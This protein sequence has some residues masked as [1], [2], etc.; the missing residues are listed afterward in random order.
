MDPSHKTVDELI[1]HSPDL[2]AV[3]ASL[4]QEEEGSVD[5]WIEDLI[6]TNPVVHSTFHSVAEDEGTPIRRMKGAAWTRALELSLVALANRNR[7][8]EEKVRGLLDR[9]SPDPT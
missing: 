7:K 8:L 2:D 1:E 5:A 4:L 6:R 9:S 3:T